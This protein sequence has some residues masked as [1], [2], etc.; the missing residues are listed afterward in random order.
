MN[1]KELDEYINKLQWS[2]AKRIDLDWI[3]EYI[4][5]NSQEGSK[6]RDYILAML[7]SWRFDMLE[8][9]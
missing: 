9:D 3:R 2:I 5:M 8:E 1:D 7:E 6:E 4:K